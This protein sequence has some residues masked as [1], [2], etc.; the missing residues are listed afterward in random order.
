[1]E[2]VKVVQRRT[3]RGGITVF[4]VEGVP[5]HYNRP[6]KSIITRIIS[7]KCQHVGV[8][9]NVLHSWKKRSSYRDVLC[10]VKYGEYRSVFKKVAVVNK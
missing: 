10:H 3:V 9:K 2:A 4:E 5:F 1:M 8:C 6:I 7:P